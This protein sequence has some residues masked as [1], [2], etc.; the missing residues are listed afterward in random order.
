MNVAS[1]CRR[2]VVSIPAS[3]TVRQAATLMRDEHVGALA[4][5]DPYGPGRVIGIVTDR[6]LVIDLLAAGHPVDQAIGSVCHTELAGVPG[7][8]S[9]GEAVQA[10]QRGGV[11]R[12][13]VLGDDNAVV[14]L[15][16]TDDLFEAIAGELDTLASTL[17]GG[18]VR[19]GTRERARARAQ[20]EP[21][22]TLYAAAHEA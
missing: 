20:S 1:L 4:V 10:M 2:E 17:R 21:P 13:L 8:A 12:L 5:T 11:R 9:I 6:D 7:A 16:S 19:E 15:V 14:G 3:A 18:V 22:R